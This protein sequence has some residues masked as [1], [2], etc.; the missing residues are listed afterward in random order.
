[1][2]GARLRARRRGSIGDAAPNLS[3]PV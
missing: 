3:E 1:M 2:L